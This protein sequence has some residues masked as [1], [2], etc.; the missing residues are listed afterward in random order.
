MNSF[1]EQYP[2]DSNPKQC[3]TQYTVAS[4]SSMPSCAHIAHCHA[5]CAPCSTLLRAIAHSRFSIVGQRRSILRSLAVPASSPVATHN[6][7]RDTSLSKLYNDREFFIATENHEN[8]VLTGNP[9]S[10]QENCGKSIASEF[11]CRK[12]W[13]ARVVLSCHDTM[14]SGLL[15]TLLRHNFRVMA[16]SQ[17]KLCRSKENLCIDP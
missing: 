6:L 2:M 8:P 14:P 12:P 9:S 7:C 11:I 4:L 5:R 3:T 10:R 1:Y 16:R 13:C 15:H 17:G